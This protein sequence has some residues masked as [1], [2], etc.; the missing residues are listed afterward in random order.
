[1]YSLVALLSVLACASFVL[2]FLHGRRRH[3][4][5]LGAELVALLYTHNWALFLV[6]GMAVAWGCL[7]RAG[8]VAGRDG[9][10]LAGGVALLYAPWI[11]SLLFQAASTGAP[12]A[13]KPGPVHLIEIPVVMFGYWAVPLLAVAVAAAVRRG[14]VPDVVPLLG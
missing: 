14:R 2:A 9:A 3:L 5:L 12:W 1:M 4:W 11:P 10:A 6:A 7:W 13:E 8:R